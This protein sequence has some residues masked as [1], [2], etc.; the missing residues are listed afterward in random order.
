M[1]HPPFCKP[2]S[3]DLDGTPHRTQP[4]RVKWTA[5]LDIHSIVFLALLLE[6]GVTQAATH[7]KQAI[8][9]LCVH[10]RGLSFGEIPAPTLRFLPLISQGYYPRPMLDSS[11]LFFSARLESAMP[12]MALKA[13]WR[14]RTHTEAKVKI[15]Q[16]HEGRNSARQPTNEYLW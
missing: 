3:C 4:R 8:F 7:Q 1:S 6:Y 13:L 15:R 10:V 11:F 16:M 5:A 12:I 2:H 9:E 14:A